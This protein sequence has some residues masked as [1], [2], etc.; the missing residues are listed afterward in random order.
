MALFDCVLKQNVPHAATLSV[1]KKLQP[2]AEYFF[3]PRALLKV[4][5]CAFRDGRCEHHN[6]SVGKLEAGEPCLRTGYQPRA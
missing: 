2:L 4:S 5:I 3:P 6:S 1:R